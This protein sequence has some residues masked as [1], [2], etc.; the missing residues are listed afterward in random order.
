MGWISDWLFHRGGTNDWTGFDD[1]WQDTPSVPTDTNPDAG[2][3]TDGGYSYA[4][5]DLRALQKMLADAQASAQESL[6]PMYAQLEQLFGTYD[7]ET[8]TWSGGSVNELPTFTEWMKQQGYT[9]GDTGGMQD[10]ITGLSEQL[11]GLDPNSP[12]AKAFAAEMGGFN[13][14]EDRQ[15]FMQNLQDQMQQSLA[16]SQSGELSDLQQQAVR[17]TTAEAE[18]RA[19]RLIADSFSSSGSMGQMMLQADETLNQIQDGNIQMQVQFAQQNRDIALQQYQTQVGQYAQMYQA[20]EMSATD[21]VDA[22]RQSLGAAMQGYIANM[23]AILQQ[24]DQ[25]FQQYDRDYQSI[26]DSIQLTFAG[27]QMELGLAQAEYDL[28]EQAYMLALA[29]Y[30]TAEELQAMADA[31]G[32]DWSDI[33][34]LIAAAAQ[35]IAVL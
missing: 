7:P 18:R 31:T 26:V 6:D 25:Y 20:G 2:G 1:S 9:L 8:G 32:I 16:Q 27:I 35:I 12:E 5:P 10:L 33:A 3:T 14:W 22:K 28:A 19:E 23:D 29:P 15:A 4:A 17:R 21:Y 13:T 34:S 30:Y 11:A 24:N